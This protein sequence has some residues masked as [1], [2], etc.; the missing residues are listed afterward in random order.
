MDW[1]HTLRE[2]SATACLAVIFLSGCGQQESKSDQAT[3]SGSA[4]APVVVSA[5]PS[6][7]RGM[8]QT[9]TAVFSHPSGAQSI[10]EVRLLFNADLDGRNA[11]YVYFDQDQKAF[12]LVNDAGTSSTTLPLSIS[13]SVQNSQCQLDTSGSSVMQKANQLALQV[14]LTF[15][16]AFKG[17][18]QLFLFAED[19]NQHSTGLQPAGKWSVGPEN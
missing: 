16:P 12:L 3:I 19:R 6:S 14:A 4:N 11:C 13:S 18:K 1:H 10:R 9:F 8:A 17:E 15:K 7:G 2:C 5:S